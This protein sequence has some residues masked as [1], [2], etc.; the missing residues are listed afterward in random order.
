MLIKTF[1]TVVFFSILIVFKRGWFWKTWTEEAD[2][3]EHVAQV[4]RRGLREK[5]RW[6][7]TCI[8]ACW[9]WKELAAVQLFFIKFLSC[10]F[11]THGSE[12]QD[13]RTLQQDREQLWNRKQQHRSLQETCRTSCTSN[14]QPRRRHGFLLLILSKLPESRSALSQISITDFKGRY[15]GGLLA[16][17]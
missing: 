16:H 5:W 6:L 17:C 1:D 8:L 10:L 11:L 9:G 13:V 7:D 2:T 12:P 15:R 14:E 3:R 4:W